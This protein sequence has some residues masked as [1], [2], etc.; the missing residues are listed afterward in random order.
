[1]SRRAARP[2]RWSVDAE[3]WTMWSAFIG[4]HVLFAW[5]ASWHAS[6]PYN[7]VTGVYRGWLDEAAA[8]RIPGIDTE[9]VYPVVAL[10]PMALADLIGG[11]ERYGNAWMVVVLA[12]DL[13]ALG[14]LTLRGR[15]R[16]GA[17]RRRAIGWWWVA[18]TALLGPIA[19]GR[20][21]A[22]TA[23]IA[24]LAIL[25]LRS[26]PALAGALL[27]LGA[28]IKVWPAAL[29]AAA[30]VALRRRWRL[31]GAAV[32]VCA[33]V[34]AGVVAI[35]GAGALP[36]ALSF[37]T[38]QTGRGLQ[39][40]S[41][42]ASGFLL[43]AALGLGDYEIAFD[44]EILTMQISGPGT[45]AASAILTPLMLVLVLALVVLAVRAQRRG[46]GAAGRLSALALGIVAAFIVA[47]K[48]GSPQFI[49]WLGPVIVLGMLV[50]GH[51]FG[52]VA[53]I[54]LCA[55][56][57]TQLIYPWYY[58]QIIAATPAGALTLLVR[59]LLVAALL[60]WSF[61]RLQRGGRARA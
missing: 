48:V 1:M 2:R 61:A 57:L 14:R 8:G 13:L 32:A 44:E 12:L 22:I 59:N 49:V 56:A 55:A 36:N 34:L 17:D 47:N 20:I 27:T 19:F 25:W 26:R 38:E 52:A 40:E 45:A 4:L 29:F 16:A 21:D 33:A 50:N 10:V 5:I 15:E 42:A 41:T 18:F 11:H 37:V 54:G 31:V 60:V 35:G 39:L 53:A 30:F 43:L 23:P 9:F 3:L 51:R 58:W 6:V 24:I 7:D 46:M 28:W